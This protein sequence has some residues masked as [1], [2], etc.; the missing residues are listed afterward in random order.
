MG[1]DRIPEILKRLQKHYP[2]LSRRLVEADALSRWVS[3]VGPAIAK[4]AKAVAV[5]EGVLVVEVGHPI[6]RTE[7]H[8]RKRQILEILNQGATPKEAPLIDILFVDP[9]N[10]RY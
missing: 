4:N 5:R 8:H 1:F 10:T 6:W 9:G 3:A 2:G 7:L